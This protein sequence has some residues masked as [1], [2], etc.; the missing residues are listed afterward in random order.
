[1]R[2]PF[3]LRRRRKMPQKHTQNFTLEHPPEL[4]RSVPPVSSREPCPGCWDWWS[5]AWWG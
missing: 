3:E 4:A 2:E 1:M 5:S